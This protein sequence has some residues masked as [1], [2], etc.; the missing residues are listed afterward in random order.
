MLLRLLLLAVLVAPLSATAVTLGQLD[1]FEDGTVQGWGAGAMHPAPPSNVATGGP[2]G[3]DDSYLLLT[4]VG[5]TGAGSRLV[6]FNGVQW[7]GNYSGAGVTGIAMDVNN[8]GPNPL[9][10]RVILN[11]VSN[12]AG[13]TLAIPLPSAG[14]WTSIF[15]PIAPEDLSAVFGSPADVLASVVELRLIHLPG[16][17]PEPIVA[18]LGV[19]NIRA[20]PEPSTL[21]LVAL[22][23]LALAS[24][25]RFGRGSQL[26]MSASTSSPPV[27]PSRPFDQRS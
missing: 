12:F 2:S 3:A 26:T 14:G 8:F 13:S 18:S 22:G 19:D 16:G 24:T 15:F 5:G 1:D 9:Q 20:V 10:L 27:A 25:Q 17:T 7:A 6:V 11:A 4:S 21:A 23:M